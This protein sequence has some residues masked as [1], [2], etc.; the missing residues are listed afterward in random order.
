[1]ELIACM[2]MLPVALKKELV[3]SVFRFEAPRDHKPFTGRGICKPF[4]GR[5][6]R[7]MLVMRIDES[8][9]IC[10]CFR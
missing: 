1:M 4:T 6:G 10:N 3:R 7:T 8:V 2:C 9:R 5:G